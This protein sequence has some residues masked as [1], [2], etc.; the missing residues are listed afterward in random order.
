MKGEFHAPE[1]EPEFFPGE[2]Y[3]DQ[4]W[5]SDFANGIFAVDRLM[6]IRLLMILILAAFFLYA[7]RKPQLIPRGAQNVAE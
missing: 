5:F 2:V 6:I 7:F 1:M 3:P 4:L